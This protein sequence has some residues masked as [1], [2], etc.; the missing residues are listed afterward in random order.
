MTHDVQNL[1]EGVLTVRGEA[2]FARV[3]GG[4][5]HVWPLGGL[6][7]NRASYGECFLCREL[8]PE[9][10]KKPHEMIA[11]LMRIIKMSPA[12]CLDRTAEKHH[13]ASGGFGAVRIEVLKH[14]ADDRKWERGR[15][16][17][18]KQIVESSLNMT[19]SEHGLDQC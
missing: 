5:S 16:V 17:A 12:P 15:V 14:I 2:D 3:T 13:S 1:E 19:V 4:G 8:C 10:S 9:M 6:S 18:A 11:L 7:H